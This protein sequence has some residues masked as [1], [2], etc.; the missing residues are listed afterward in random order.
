MSDRKPRSDRGARR[1]IPCAC[2]RHDM[3]FTA[4]RCKRCASEAR[5]AYWKA[6]HANGKAGKVDLSDFPDHIIEARYQR[7]VLQRRYAAATGKVAA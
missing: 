2:G 1:R 4:K 5:S 6:R 3:E 7:A